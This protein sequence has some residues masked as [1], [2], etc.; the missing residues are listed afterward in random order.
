MVEKALCRKIP[1][2]HCMTELNKKPPKGGDQLLYGKERFI[3]L[4]PSHTKDHLVV[5]FPPCDYLT[6]NAFD[7]PLT[8]IKDHKMA[9]AR[10]A[11]DFG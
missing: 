8:I 5:V 7:A 3:H 10:S 11:L 9:W 1:Q 6:K 4:A 2:D